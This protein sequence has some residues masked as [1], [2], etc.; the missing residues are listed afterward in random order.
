MTEKNRPLDNFEEEA[1]AFI[2]QRESDRDSERDSER[3]SAGQDL[4]LIS[5]AASDVADIW[6][7]FELLDANSVDEM[8]AAEIAVV[9]EPYEKPAE[10]ATAL[11]QNVRKKGFSLKS[12]FSDMEQSVQRYFVWSAGSFGDSD[13]L[14]RIADASLSW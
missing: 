3:D 8:I 9:P 2:R 5:G 14:Y 10:S 7:T 13:A 12:L 11:G 4:S 6:N 1:L